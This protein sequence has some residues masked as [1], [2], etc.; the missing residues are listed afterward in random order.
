MGELHD[1]QTGKVTG[2]GYDVGHHTRLT[3]YQLEQR[4]PLILTV[5]AYQRGGQQTGE[6]PHTQQYVQLIPPTQH[7]EV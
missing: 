4:P 1:V 6:Y 5:K 3:L 7:T 2:Y